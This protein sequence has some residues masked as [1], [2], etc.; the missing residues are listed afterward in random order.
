MSSSYKEVFKDILF[1]LAK[2]REA[3]KD[4][5]EYLEGC[6]R[7]FSKFEAA[8]A[9]ISDG[10]VFIDSNSK[11]MLEEI[12]SQLTAEETYA[13]AA[14]VLRDIANLNRLLNNE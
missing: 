5:S 7:V 1:E 6:D 13:N 4:S 14:S 8:L 10:D 11:E 12:Y 3:R 2:L 9:D